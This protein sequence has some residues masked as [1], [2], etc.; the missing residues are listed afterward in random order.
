MQQENISILFFPVFA[1]FAFEK[2]HVFSLKHNAEDPQ[3]S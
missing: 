3:S 2:F 1:Y